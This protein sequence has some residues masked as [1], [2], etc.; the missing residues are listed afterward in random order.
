M[1][2]VDGMSPDR[3]DPRDRRRPR[4]GRD[5]DP[6]RRPT[7]A[8]DRRQGR[9][10]QADDALRVPG[11]GGRARLRHPRALRRLQGSST[12]SCES[13]SRSTRPGRSPSW[14]STSAIDSN[15]SATLPPRKRSPGDA[16]G[17]A[18][19]PSTALGPITTR[20]NIRGY[21]TFIILDHRGVIRFK[22][23][24]PFDPRFDPTIEALVKDAVAGGR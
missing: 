24:H 16:G 7:R 23:L 14:G 6:R 18:T 20:W 8:G 13:W 2:Y 3:R 12:R 19:T 15:S 1:T 17:M 21:P 5:P 11:E 9:R 10:R 4:A 22:D